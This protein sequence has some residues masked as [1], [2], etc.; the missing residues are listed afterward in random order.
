MNY[1]NLF[2]DG[3]EI[4]TGLATLYRVDTTIKQI[5]Y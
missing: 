3:I 4:I 1:I 5:K 2:D